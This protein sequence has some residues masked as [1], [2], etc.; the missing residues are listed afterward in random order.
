MQ[1]VEL[2]NANQVPV[3][4]FYENRFT[5]WVMEE[6]CNIVLKYDAM[7]YKRMVIFGRHRP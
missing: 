2:A 6:G 1:P 5:L 4:S 3:L 7:Q